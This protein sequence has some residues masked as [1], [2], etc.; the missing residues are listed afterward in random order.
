MNYE[1]KYLKYKQKYLSLKKILMGG[2]C[3]LRDTDCI[4]REMKDNKCDSIECIIEKLKTINNT[5]GTQIEVISKLPM[6]VYISEYVK[7]II[8]LDNQ[9]TSDDLCHENIHEYNHLVTEL[10][11]TVYK[12]LGSTSEHVSDV[13]K[14]LL[15]IAPNFHLSQKNMPVRS[16]DKSHIAAR[17]K[18]EK[19]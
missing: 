14:L 13:S 3:E 5:F 17:P 12:Y 8:R 15:A 1:Q 11:Q 19:E 4:L 10:Q 7:K 16:V 2:A 6:F 9:C 18:K